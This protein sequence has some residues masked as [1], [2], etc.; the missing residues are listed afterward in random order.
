MYYIIYL[1]QNG[2]LCKQLEI[3][4]DITNTNMDITGTD[5]KVLNLLVE[6]PK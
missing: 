5:I 4:N 6:S 2:I 3:S 1:R